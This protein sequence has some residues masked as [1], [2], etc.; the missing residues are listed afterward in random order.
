MGGANRAAHIEFGCK[1]IN[2][3]QHQP[4]L[5]ESLLKAQPRRILQRS[6]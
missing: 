6:H 2:S 5:C 3:P 1:L 4:M